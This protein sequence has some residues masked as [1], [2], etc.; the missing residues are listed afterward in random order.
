MKKLF[1]VLC[2]VIMFFGIV[3]YPG[4]GANSQGGIS[5]LKSTTSA[6]V[7]ANGTSTETATLDQQGSNAVPEPATLLLLGTG[8]LGVGIL[9]RKR[10]KK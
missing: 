3:G 9:A 8:L 4:D 1:W 10:F 2:V 5:T 6:P 7:A